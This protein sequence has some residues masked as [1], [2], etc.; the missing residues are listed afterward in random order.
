ME[1][2]IHTIG[3]IILY[4]RRQAAPNTQQNL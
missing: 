1:N 4:L 2:N 3:I